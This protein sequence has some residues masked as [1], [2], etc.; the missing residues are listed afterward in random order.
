MKH[1]NYFTRTKKENHINS[2]RFRLDFLNHYRD[3]ITANRI[4]NLWES[5]LR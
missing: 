5:I 3:R 1:K 2:I 4:L